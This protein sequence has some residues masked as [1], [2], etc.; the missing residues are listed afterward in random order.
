[1]SLLNKCLCI[2]SFA[3]RLH[4]GYLLEA[5]RSHPDLMETKQA[6]CFILKDSPVSEFYG[7]PCLKVIQRDDRFML[8]VSFRSVHADTE[9][10]NL[11]EYLKFPDIVSEP[12]K[13]LWGTVDK[14]DN[15]DNFVTEIEAAVS[16]MREINT[17][18]IMAGLT[19]S[20]PK[21]FWHSL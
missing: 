7:H 15:K 3:D 18:E 14:E 5:L 11:P 19:N 9:W 1:M 21:I 20:T 8:I 13:D 16:K 4:M 12:S 2:N 17:L 10:I 6:R